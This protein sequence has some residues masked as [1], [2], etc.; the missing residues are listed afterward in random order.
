MNLQDFAGIAV[1]FGSINIVFAMS[2]SAMVMN[3]LDNEPECFG[4]CP[5]VFSCSTA[6]LMAGRND[7]V[8]YVGPSAFCVCWLEE[9]RAYIRVSSCI[10]EVVKDHRHK[11]LSLYSGSLKD[12]KNICVLDIIHQ[13]Y[14]CFAGGKQWHPTPAVLL[15]GKSPWMEGAW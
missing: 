2:F 11:S 15:P 5:Q 4:K 13:P 3:A 1:F 14:R 9:P 7:C 12:Y 8:L 10:L 6:G